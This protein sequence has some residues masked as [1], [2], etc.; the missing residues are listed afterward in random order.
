AGGRGG[1]PRREPAAAVGAVGG[2]APPLARALLLEQDVDPAAAQLVPAAAV[3]DLE[4]A[5][6]RDLLPLL[7]GGRRHAEAADA[8]RGLARL[9]RHAV[10]P[11]LGGVGGLRA[12]VLGPVPAG[13]GRADAVVE[14]A[15]TAG[16]GGVDPLPGVAAERAEG[17]VHLLAGEGLPA[18][19][20]LDPQRAG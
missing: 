10:G 12:V 13:P 11:A 15:V 3:L 19:R 5:L 4:Q 6:D 20:R 9:D 14:A 1:D 2:D 16:A 18:A 7:H 17:D 8:G